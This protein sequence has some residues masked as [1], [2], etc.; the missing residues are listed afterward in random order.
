MRTKEET[1]GGLVLNLLYI[2]RT[3]LSCRNGMGTLRRFR[4][5]V[6]LGSVRGLPLS[7]AREEVCHLLRFGLST[8]YIAQPT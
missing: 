8:A 6:Q 1:H 3:L 4:A 5:I 2:R 7:G